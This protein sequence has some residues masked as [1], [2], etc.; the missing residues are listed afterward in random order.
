MHALRETARQGLGGGG[1]VCAAAE[2]SARK[3]VIHSSG[4]R[5]TAGKGRPVLAPSDSTGRFQFLSSG[6]GCPPFLAD[7][8]VGHTLDL[9]ATQP[10]RAFMAAPGSFHCLQSRVEQHHDHHVS[11]AAECHLPSP[12]SW[13]GFDARNHEPRGIEV[14]RIFV[15]EIRN[16]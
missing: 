8:A 11:D 13:P 5:L 1:A 9:A 4:K 2:L 7:D 16:V 15:G 6:A 12:F 14:V 10:V 3:H